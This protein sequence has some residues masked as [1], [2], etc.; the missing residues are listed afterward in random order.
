MN[1][2]HYFTISEQRNAHG[3]SLPIFVVTGLHFFVKYEI[4]QRS[5]YYCYVICGI[6]V[7]FTSF[8]FYI[9]CLECDFF[10]K[11]VIELAAPGFLD[12]GSRGWSFEA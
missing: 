4:D 8:V 5:H 12:P 2:E 6:S 11:L 9:C 3:M 10:I 7:I 1:T